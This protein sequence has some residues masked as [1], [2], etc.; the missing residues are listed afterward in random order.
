MSWLSRCVFQPSASSR[1]GAI[2][3]TNFEAATHRIGAGRSAGLM[4]PKC[5]SPEVRASNLRPRFLST[6]YRCCN[7]NELFWVTRN[8]LYPAV[9]LTIT[10]V[11]GVI[12]GA[13]LW[14]IQEESAQAAVPTMR[15]V[16]ETKRAALQTANEPSANDVQKP[17][18]PSE[19]PKVIEGIMREEAAR[20]LLLSPSWSRQYSAERPSSSQYAK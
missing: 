9:V 11:V 2:N 8:L 19:L 10:G 15:I 7:C 12:V 5:K 1:V 13:F 4:C 14:W 17:P 6:P 20:E 3:A 16:K 18:D